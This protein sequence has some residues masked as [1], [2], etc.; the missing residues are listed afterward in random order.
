M[1]PLRSRVGSPGETRKKSILKKSD[2]VNGV[3]RVA[4]SAAE[5]ERLLPSSGENGGSSSLTPTPVV[6][7]RP[8]PPLLNRASVLSASVVAY[9]SHTHS[10]YG[11]PQKTDS[12]F[13]YRE[14]DR[15]AIGELGKQQQQQSRQQQRPDGAASASCTDL[16]SSSAANGRSLSPPPES[17]DSVNNV[18]AMVE[19][20]DI[21]TS[22]TTLAASMAAAAAAAASGSSKFERGRD[23]SHCLPNRDNSSGN[24]AIKDESGEVKVKKDHFFYCY[25]IRCGCSS[26]LDF[27]LK[28]RF[29]SIYSWLNQIQVHIHTSY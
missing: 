23:P 7:K 8:L 14:D 11:Q 18:R 6:A 1:T 13:F 3:G 5:T 22:T 9:Y 16:K 17:A 15:E 24:A 4:A 27:P 25:P 10:N 20:R 29:K 2:T 28:Y 19:S 12:S 26:T 21:Q